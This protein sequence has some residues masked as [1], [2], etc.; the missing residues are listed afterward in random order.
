MASLEQ[1]YHKNFE[2]LLWTR[3]HGEHCRVSKTEKHKVLAFKRF[4]LTTK[5]YYICK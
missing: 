3:P 1:I 5:I 4:K 2:H